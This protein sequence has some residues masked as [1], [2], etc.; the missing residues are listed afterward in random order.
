MTMMSNHKGNVM[1][2]EYDNNG[3]VVNMLD[4]LGNSVTLAYDPLDR[5]VKIF[6]E[7]MGG[8]S[9]ETSNIDIPARHS[10]PQGMGNVMGRR[11]TLP[12]N[13]ILLLT[14]SLWTFSLR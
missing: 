14:R 2:Y 1:Q 6:D 3:N 5:P 9:G 7:N 4:S 8:P 13:L 11:V 10:N 12:Q